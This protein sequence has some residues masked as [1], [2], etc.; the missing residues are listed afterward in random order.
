M[1]RGYQEGAGD[2]E[3]LNSLPN[4][5]DFFF[6]FVDYFYFL[7]L[8]VIAEYEHIRCLYGEVLRH[9]VALAKPFIPYAGGGSRD[10]RQGAS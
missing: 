2:L 10:V 7:F 3:G 4:V 1:E 6:G 9:T 5:K 8:I